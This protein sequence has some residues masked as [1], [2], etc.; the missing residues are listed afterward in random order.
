MN[1]KNKKFYKLGQ[2][3][4]IVAVYNAIHLD[5]RLKNLRKEFIFCVDC[6][7]RRAVHWEHRDY[8]KP[9]EVEPVCRSCNYKRGQGIIKSRTKK[10]IK[11]FA[12]K[13]EYGSGKYN[14]CK[15][16]CNHF[17]YLRRKKE[18]YYIDRILKIT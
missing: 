7:K 8:N 1:K 10:K 15:K 4:A 16:C 11:C 14:L 3:S 9:L 12:C 6:K 18:Q 2:N 13:K 17:H 5:R